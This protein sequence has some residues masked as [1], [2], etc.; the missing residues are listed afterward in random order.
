MITVKQGDE[1]PITY[2]LNMNL[3]G[4]TVILRARKIG[5]P[6]P[7]ILA[8][9]ITDAA[10]GVITHTLTGTLPV[11]TYDVEAEVTVAGQVISFPTSQTGG[12]KYDTLIVQPELD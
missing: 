7:V 1:Y 4:A 9:T 6:T 2:T 8:A 3:T 5:D 12:P 10:G 11:G